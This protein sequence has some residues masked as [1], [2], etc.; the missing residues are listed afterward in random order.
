MKERYTVAVIGAGSGGR[1][2][3]RAADASERFELKAVADINEAA[4]LE[5]EAQY[6]GVRTY[7]DYASLFRACPTDVVVVA[8]WPPSHLEITRAALGLPLTGIVVEKPLA[9]SYLAGVATLEA[10]RAAGIPMATPHGLRVLPHSTEIIERVRGGEIGDLIL[11]EI[12]CAQWDII[13]AGIHWLNFAVALIEPDPFVQVLAQCDTSTRTYRDGMQVETEAVTYAVSQNGVRVVMHTGD[14]TPVAQA[15]EGFLFRLVGT[16][17]LI[18]FYGWKPVYRIVSRRYPEGRR[19][20]L[21]PTTKSGH[22]LHL[23]KLASHMDAGAPDYSIPASSLA[24]LELVEA[25]YLSHRIRST[26]KLPLTTFTP[27]A[28]SG[29]TPGIAYAGTGGGRDGRKL[30]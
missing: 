26:V 11:V 30:G 7:S 9:D 2:S 3:I 24:A 6:P 25:A 22:Q 20:E 4:R 12:E 28:E 23:E 5:I 18:E 1:L 15:G 14:Y 19:V 29:W 16:T 10:V 27:P 21:P 13:N 8:T 17:G